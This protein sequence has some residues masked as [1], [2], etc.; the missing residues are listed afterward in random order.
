VPESGASGDVIAFITEAAK[1]Y[2]TATQ[3]LAEFRATPGG[4]VSN[5]VWYRTFARVTQGYML[6]QGW[7]SR[8]LRHLPA[9][10][11]IGEWEA[12][13]PGLY[14][15]HMRI[16]V[17]SSDTGLTTDRYYTYLSDTLI[18]PSTAMLYGIADYQAAVDVGRYPQS[19]GVPEFRGVFETV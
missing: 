19:L 16:P 17:T 7:Q 15:Y 10:N 2:K 5:D 8:D 6:E 18:A 1:Q 3:A 12:G 13:T 11:M 14:A 9:P 4:R